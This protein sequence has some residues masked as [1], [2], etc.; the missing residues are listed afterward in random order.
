[1]LKALFIDL[2]GVLYEGDKV[3]PGAVAAIE[4]ARASQLQLRFVTNTSRKTRAQLLNDLQR[5]GFEVQEKELFTAPVAVHAWLQEKKLRPYCLIHRNIKSEFADLLQ[6]MPNAVVI[7]DAEQNFCYDKLN[8]AFQLCQQGAVLVGIGYNRYFK[9]EGQLLLDAGPFIKAIEFAASAPA[10][11][12]GKPSKDFFLQALGSTDLSV[13]QVL[14]I[15]DD[16]YGDIEGAINAGLLAGLVR[17]GKYQTGDEHK[18]SAAHLT[19]NS[20]VDAVDYALS[21]QSHH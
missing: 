20:I 15:G 6:T 16:I 7:G 12:I 13:D 9:L 18:I 21:D 10:I 14:M 5:L 11:I 19:F 17:T 2:S 1:M 4:K 8:R 3:I